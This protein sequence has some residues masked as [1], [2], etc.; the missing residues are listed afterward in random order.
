M[1]KKKWSKKKIRHILVAVIAVLIIVLAAVYTLFI[2]PN[3]HKEE[4]IY[5]EHA[6][7][8]GI[9]RDEVTESGTVTFGITTQNYELDVT[10]ETEDEN[11]DDEEEEE[12]KYLKVEDVYVAVGQRI[13]EGDAIYKF[14]EES[15]ADV[16]KALTYAKTEAQIALSQAQTNYSIGTITAGLS[17]EETL[18]S[19]SLAQQEYDNSVV[20]LTIEMAAKSLEIEQLLVDI[21]EAQLALVEEDYREQRAD[22]I[23]QY[24]DAIEKLEDVSED[25]VTNRVEAHESFLSVK[26]SYEKFFESFDQ[27]TEEIDEKVKQVYKLQEEI[28]FN[29]QLIEKD[30]L[31]ASQK[32]E[33][34]TLK[35]QIADLKYQ[36]N[37]S[38]YENALNKAQED[39]Q[40]AQD[41]L[42]AFENFVG[43]GVVYA[44]GTGIITELGYEVDDYL[45]TEGTLVSYACAEDMTIS[46]DVS[47]EDV[48]A[49][50]VGDRVEI[51]FA[52][53]EDEVYEGVIE[54]ITTT[55]TS[56]N[57]A[58]ISYPVVIAI[59]GDTSKL[60]G[61]MTADITFV[62][63]ETP[64]VVY[65]S[66]KAI[67]EQ[68]GKK[69]VY[70]MQGDE[71]VLSPVT[72]GFTAGQNVAIESGLEA[73]ETHF[74]RTVVTEREKQEKEEETFNEKR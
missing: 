38:G 31:S 42:D 72:T 66:R 60:Y 71:Y 6:A 54:S 12:E 23:E 32:Y 65:I 14:S 45:I 39:L 53:Y 8:S 43:D 27:S 68:N 70:K 40:E 52:T 15:I 24:E 57:S 50:K 34:D 69:Y 3:L 37:L 49:M 73:G 74:I 1:S 29:Q 18:L 64:E 63:E 35:A 10:T 20:K 67:V 22:L 28:L 7:Q 17:K 56:R 33:S 48:V 44:A 36:S 30:L 47:Q 16:R 25:F 46:V 41:K 13:Q 51:A 19:A 4:I 21:Y 26:D 61:G 5:T 59:Q 2:Q 11:D 62:V 55:A 9:L 58:T